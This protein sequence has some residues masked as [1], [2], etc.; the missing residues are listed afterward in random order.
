MEFQTTI[1]DVGESPN[2]V[3]SGEMLKLRKASKKTR[4]PIRN[5]LIL[6]MLYRHGLRE[7]ELCRLR[8]DLLDFERSQVHIRRLKGSNRFTHPV[9]GDEMR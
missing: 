1:D 3:S 5:E 6:L 4:N 8:L 7:T 2:W 9:P